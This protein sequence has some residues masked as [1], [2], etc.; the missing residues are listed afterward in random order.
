VCTGITPAAQAQVDVDFTNAAG[1][2]GSGSGG[3]SG[4]GGALDEVLL[5]AL[6]ASLLVSAY[7]R[8]RAHRLKRY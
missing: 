6:S 2:G 4:G 1:S 3:G 7:G 8:I 5:L